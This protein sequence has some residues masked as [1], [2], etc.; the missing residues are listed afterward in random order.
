[1]GQPNDCA[2]LSAAEV[3]Q[4]NNKDSCWIAVRGKVY[5]VTGRVA[6]IPF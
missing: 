5:D 1:M 2:Q 3:S 6:F 4:H